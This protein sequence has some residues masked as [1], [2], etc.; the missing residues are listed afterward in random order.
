[1]GYVREQD[2]KPWYWP[3]FSTFRRQPDG[4]VQRVA[5]ASFGPGD[6]Y[7]GVFHLFGLLAD[8]LDGWQPKF[9]Y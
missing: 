7:C 8:G 2:G 4:S 5:H 6:P 9:S 1:M 3:G